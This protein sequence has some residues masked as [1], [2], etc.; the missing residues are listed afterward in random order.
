MAIGAACSR[1][2]SFPLENRNSYTKASS[3]EA[4]SPKRETASFY[5]VILRRCLVDASRQN[6]VYG[7][8]TA[9]FYNGT[10]HPFGCVCYR[11]ADALHLSSL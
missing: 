7:I 1:F 8:L 5:A 9:S 6:A 11:R 3:K 2:A 10:I 4:V